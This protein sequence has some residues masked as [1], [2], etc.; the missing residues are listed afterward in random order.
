M[1]VTK[2][3]RLRWEGRLAC[4][5]ESRDACS[6]LVRKPVGRKPLERSR[7]RWEDN[8]KMNFGEVE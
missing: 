1:R 6:V 3:R 7:R 2:S 4:I 5:G 8:I